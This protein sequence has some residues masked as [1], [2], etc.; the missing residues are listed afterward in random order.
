MELRTRAVPIVLASGIVLAGGGAVIAASGGSSS[1]QS[2]AKQQYC[3]NGKPKPPHHN[4]GK[5]PPPKK[6]HHKKPK[7]KVHKRPNHRCY[8]SHGFRYQV[9]IA[10]APK[11]RRVYVYRDGHRVKRT[12]KHKF[13]VWIHPKH[14]RA[15]THR[16]VFRVR[17][18]DGKMHKKTVTYRV[19]KKKHKT[20]HKH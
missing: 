10:N 6:H 1:H 2:A 12:K 5:K 20:H 15:G 8:R 4:C 7:F 19:C 14:Q 13:S 9:S 18:S 17:G 3:P 16:V 11:G